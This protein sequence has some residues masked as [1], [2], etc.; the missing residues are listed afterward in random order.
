MANFLEIGPDDV[1]DAH[2][3]Q[4]LR[5]YPFEP[6]LLPREH[7][8]LP[9][10]PVRSWRRELRRF[11][12]G[13]VMRNPRDLLAHTQRVLLELRVGDADACFGALIDLFIVL[14]PRGRALKRD[15]LRQTRPLLGIERTVFLY[16]HLK[17]GLT[18]NDVFPAGSPSCLASGVTGRTEFLHTPDRGGGGQSVSSGALS[19]EDLEPLRLYL[20]HVVE[21]DPGDAGHVAALLE[22]Y[23]AG[24]LVRPF[25][26]MHARLMGRRVALPDEWAALEREFGGIDAGPTDPMTQG[27]VSG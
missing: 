14:G 4:S 16:R 7:A 17:H 1:A 18:A 2:L 9:D 23:R 22:I 15:L 13:V 5:A 10:Y 12:R 26:A 21:S 6:A 25:R 20:E 19:G 27:R 11:L 8:L 24:G 3:V